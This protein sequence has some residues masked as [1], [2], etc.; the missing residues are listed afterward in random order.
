VTEKTAPRYVLL[1]AGGH[2]RVLIDAL[3]AGA[4]LVCLERDERLW[5]KSFGGALVRGGDELLAEFRPGAVLL[6]NGLGANPST[7]ARRG[8]FE[9]AKALGH[10]FTRVVSPLAFLSPSATLGEGAQLL[11]HA[12]VHSGAVVGENAVV[13]T[14]AVVEHDARIGRHAFVGPGAVVCGEAVIDEGAFIG[15]GAIVLPGARIGANAVI[16]A[17]V[18]AHGEVPAESRLI[19]APRARRVSGGGLT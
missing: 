13:N 2:G 11:T 18:V 19:G 3:G 15:A 1:G 17:G 16:G 7:A 8:L 4:T 10:D 5:G 14:A 9:R 6:V 12:V